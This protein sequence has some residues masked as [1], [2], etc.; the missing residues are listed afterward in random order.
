VPVRLVVYFLLIGLPVPLLW[1]A[2]PHTVAVVV[3]LGV[4]ELAIVFG[5]LMRI[6]SSDE[7][8]RLPR[9]QPVQP[10]STKGL[11]GPLRER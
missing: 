7:L 2:L 9:R 11:D 6:F 10:P 5:G 8:A 4:L 1:L 3:V